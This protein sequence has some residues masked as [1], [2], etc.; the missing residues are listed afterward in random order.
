MYLRQ[1]KPPVL[2]FPSGKYFLI[3]LYEK[4]GLSDNQIYMK[5]DIKQTIRSILVEFQKRNLPKPM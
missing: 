3:H 5:D 1:Q 4:D 2:S